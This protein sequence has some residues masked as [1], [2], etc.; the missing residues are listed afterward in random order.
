MEINSAINLT[1]E[2]QSSASQVDNEMN[3]QL[4]KEIHPK[5]V[6]VPFNAGG[7]QQLGDQHQFAAHI[8][9]QLG[10]PV[11]PHLTGRYQTKT[12]VQMILK[13]LQAIN[14]NHLLV[15]RGDDIKGRPIQSAFPH[16]SDLMELIRAVAPDF[17]MMGA[18]Y[19]EGH[20]QAPDLT[21]DIMNLKFKVAAGCEELVTQVGFDN[22]IIQSF[23][24]QVRSIGIQVPI[25]VGIL[26]V[27]DRDRVLKMIRLT[28]VTVPKR[29]A[30]ILNITDPDEFQ[31]AGLQFTSDQM[32]ALVRLGI[33]N[34]H[35]Y[36]LNH[37]AFLQRLVQDVKVE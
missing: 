29:L 5:A 37:R 1:L 21:T 14:I 16:A 33:T 15:L 25:R 4:L 6:F 19:P 34:I 8:Q 7:N 2:I 17:Q 11:V 26:P 23:L 9:N 12:G 3:W 28:G 20:Y 22:H 18:C 30:A 32:N 24:K 13:Q 31:R 35:L 27:I 10:I 36:T